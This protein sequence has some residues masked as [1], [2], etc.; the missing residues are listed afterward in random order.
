MG[1]GVELAKVQAGLRA[2]NTA[3]RVDVD[4][5]HAR[6]VDHHTGVAHRRAGD[7]VATAANGDEQISRS[8]EGDGCDDIIGTSAINHRGG[9][10]IDHPVPDPTR[11]VIV[12]IVRNDQIA[13]N[14]L[15]ELRDIRGLQT[16]LGPGVVL[17]PESAH[18]IFPFATPYR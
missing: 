2:R 11:L 9:S 10:P 1:G 4:L 7:V 8:G 12:G 15:P 18:R 16:R 13:A 5:L 14:G 6:Y 3:N 17:K